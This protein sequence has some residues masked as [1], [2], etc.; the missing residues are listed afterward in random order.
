MTF[1]FISI[2]IVVLSVFAGCEADGS[3]KPKSTSDNKIMPLG[4]SRVE[5][6]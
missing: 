6:A 5:G 3:L 1:K 2:A 4:A